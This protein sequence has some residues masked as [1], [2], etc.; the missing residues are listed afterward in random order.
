MTFSTKELSI[1]Y[2]LNYENYVTSSEISKQFYF[3]PKTV[4]R[5]IKK[6]NDVGKELFDKEIIFSEPGKTCLRPIQIRMIIM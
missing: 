1:I 4:Y 6:I 5:I 2:F 3:T